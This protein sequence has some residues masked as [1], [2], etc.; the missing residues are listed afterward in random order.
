MIISH[1]YRFIF[2]KSRKTAGT[3]LELALGRF[4][5]EDDVLTPIRNESDETKAAAAYPGERNYRVPLL[6]LTPKDVAKLPLRGRA[7]FEE[8]SPAAFVRARV[9]RAVWSD[10]L[11]FSIERNPYDRYVSEYFWNVRPNGQY[12]GLSMEEHVR[13]VPRY[14][15]SNW[16]VYAIGGR[17]VVDVM[18]HYETLAEDIR[19][20]ERRLGLPEPIVLPQTKTKQRPSKSHH[21]EV[22][23]EEV[24]ARVTEACR[25]E[26]E[27]FGYTAEQS[28][29]TRPSGLEVA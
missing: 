5:G 20:L 26:L 3:S 13:R 10:Y 19:A 11:K 29:P 1:K 28:A 17:P 18:L 15:L 16:D 9:G 8:H 2:L 4:C 14:R 25:N 21:S 24:R 7:E 6:R 23:S 27:Y 12:R 22:L